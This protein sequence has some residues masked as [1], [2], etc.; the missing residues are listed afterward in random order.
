MAMRFITGILL[1]ILLVPAAARAEPILI[2]PD[3]V[4]DGAAMH[5]GWEVLV[6]G[7]H[8]V[9]AGADLDAPEGTRIVALPGTTLLPGFIEGHSHLFLR[10]YAIA[11][12]D[13]QV[14]YESDALRTVR[15]V[16]HARTALLAGFTTLR[17]L[18][19]EGAGY[20]DVAL[21]QA[22]EQG[23]VP[24]PRLLVATRALVATGAYGPAP[25]D[26]DGAVHYGAEEADGADLVTAVRRQ[27]GGGAT[28][29]KLYA[30]HGGRATFTQEELALAVATAHQAG[31][32]VAIHA[33]TP[34][35]M[36]NAVLAG[37]DTVEHGTTGT[38]AEF[39]LM[40]EHG[41]GYCPTLAIYES[42]A[43]N[44]GWD[45]SEPAPPR[46]VAARAA[47]SA[48]LEAGVRMCMGSD[49]GGFAHGQSAREMELMVDFGM[50]AI[51]VLHAATG[52]NAEIF[53]LADRGRI[54]PGLLADLVAV[55][56]DPSRDI[57]ATRDVQLVMLGGTVVRE[58]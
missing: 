20:A 2:Q 40:A 4:F 30:D 54:A 41:T 28:V 10:P 26:P 46:I 6:E 33:S 52:G 13:D 38:R 5:P 55:A 57:S 32:Q 16:A 12:W 27:M 8:V 53:G 3:R 39:E 50:P 9:A 34:A 23:I 45:G 48:A 43:R 49:V 47:F 24:G 35:G 58:P 31:R 7:E 42:S 37:T 17:D 19:T 21:A 18:G 14:T 56:G 29:V 51:D 36:R 1:S 11:K 15:A 22:I 25:R 44:Q